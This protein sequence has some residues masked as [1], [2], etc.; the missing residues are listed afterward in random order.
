MTKP[1]NLHLKCQTPISL[2]N[3]VKRKYLPKLQIFGFPHFKTF[4]AIPFTVG[5]IGHSGY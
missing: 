2:A 4:F 5:Y 1:S 3:S